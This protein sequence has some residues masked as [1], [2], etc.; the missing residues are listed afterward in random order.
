MELDGEGGPND[1]A[2]DTDLGGDEE[3]EAPAEEFSNDNEGDAGAGNTGGQTGSSS[4]NN[5][6]A[7]VSQADFE[8][9]DDEDDS[10]DDEEDMDDYDLGAEP[11]EYMRV[12]VCAYR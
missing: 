9:S 1:A 6:K 11:G 4:S 12:C 3:Y 2:F 8:F 7:K 10:D 5:P